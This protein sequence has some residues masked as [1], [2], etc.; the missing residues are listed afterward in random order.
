MS[1]T[2]IHT[3]L[4]TSMILFAGIAGLWGVLSFLRKRSIGGDFWGI[5]AV[6]Q[7]LFL[8][9]ALVGVLLLLNNEQPARSV[10]FLYGSVAVIAIPAYFTLTKGR[11]DRAAALFYGLLCFFVFVIAF[12]AVST[13]R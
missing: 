6:G 2:Q 13:G 11:D 7:L 4:S 9:Q 12:R 8:G 5:L 3:A 1:L 10:H